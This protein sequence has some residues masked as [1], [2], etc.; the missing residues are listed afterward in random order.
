MDANIGLHDT[1][2]ALQWTRKFISKFGGDPQRT[3]AIG[4]SAGAGMLDLLLVAKDGHE[5]LPFNQVCLASS[6]HSDEA[7]A[8]IA[9]QRVWPRREPSRRQAVFDKALKAANCSSIE[10]M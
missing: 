3:T 7:E 4:S 8:F 10:C 1:M 6:A 5:V 9:L 2:A